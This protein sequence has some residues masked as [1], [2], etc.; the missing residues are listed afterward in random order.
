M[1]L[2]F[3]IEGKNRELEVAPS[4]PM[5]F[6]LGAS[7]AFA[8]RKLLDGRTPSEP[9]FSLY[10]LDP[11]D[12]SAL[13]VETPPDL[14]LE[15]APFFYAAQYAGAQA[16]VKVTQAEFFELVESTA[17]PGPHLGWIQ[18]VGRSGTT[19]ASR[20]L[21]TCQGV[22]SLSEPDVL[23]QVLALGPENSPSGGAW[24]CKDTHAHDRL[25]DACVR[26]LC[27]SALTSG[28][29][30]RLIIKPRSQF[31][32]ALPAIVRLYPHS[33][34]LFLTRAPLPWLGS[35][36]SAF[37]RDLDCDAPKVLQSFENS[38]ASYI[39]L[40]RA[41]SVPGQPQSM[42]ALW[43]L[44]YASALIQFDEATRLGLRSYAL[45]FEEL[46]ATP[47][48]HLEAFFSRLGLTWHETALSAVLE[49]D[50]QEGS[51]LAR[52]SAG[53]ASYRVKPSHIEDGAEIFREFG[54]L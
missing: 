17:D 46:Q 3:S 54:L 11:S 31:C 23:L 2:R 20:A 41:R 40:I 1:G 42:G 39:P 27:H 25:I 16:V 14:D 19:L 48:A 9:R 13:F 15:A 24:S 47:R 6:A 44:H 7:T 29:Y 8:P 50:S 49:Q 38:L 36:F 52:L 5:D 12:G 33:E 4:S 51:G 45:T 43:A 26:L 22:Y 32:E 28:R 18:S 34:T 53:R 35:V 37:L 30:E 10:C 21:G